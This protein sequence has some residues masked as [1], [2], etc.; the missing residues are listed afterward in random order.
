M[1]F[2]T[3]TIPGGKLPMTAELFKRSATAPAALVV[4]AYGT[5]GK[6]DPW[7]DM[8]RAYAEDLAK[9]GVF[10]LMPDYFARTASPHG[11]GAADHIAA[12][13]DEWA[14]AL[15][16]TVAFARTLP[17]V[18]G[19]RI[20]M[21][22]FSLGGYLCLRARAAAKPKALVEYFAPM[23]E[24]VGAPG[25]VPHVQIHHGT[26]DKFPTEFLNATKI[27]SI[28][29]VEGKDVTLY[30]YKDATHGFAAPDAA[31]TSA[32]ALSKSRTLTFF[33]TCL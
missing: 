26:Q 32:A 8:M 33:G 18:D 1:A 14:A 29:R 12:K 30:P 21:L 7:T 9:D 23:F 10:A 27:E 15:V 22:G 31:N 5:D 6:K 20:G 2:S 3:V 24:G 4:I 11:G 16:D 25:S 17:G 13:H 28:L 19:A